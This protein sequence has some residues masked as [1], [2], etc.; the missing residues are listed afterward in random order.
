MES[1]SAIHGGSNGKYGTL[2]KLSE[3]MIVDCDNADGNQGCN[4]GNQ[5][6]AFQW[7]AQEGGM[8]TEADYPYTGVDG[9]CNSSCKKVAA[10][11]I[12]GGAAVP[13]NNDTALINSVFTQPVSLSVDAS[14]LGWQFYFVSIR[15]CCV[16]L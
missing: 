6:P 11:A 4:G 5:L 13:A 9:T 8:C 7:V 10:T 16:V 2:Y 1:I 3:Q 12:K 14:S 15:R